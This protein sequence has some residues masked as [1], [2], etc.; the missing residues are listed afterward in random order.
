[1]YNLFGSWAT[2]RSCK[3]RDEHSS[4][5]L[6]HESASLGQTCFCTASLPTALND[7]T[8][9]FSTLITFS[10]LSSYHCMILVSK[11]LLFSLLVFAYSCFAK[12]SAIFCT[13][14]L[15]PL[16]SLYIP[17]NNPLIF[18][19]AFTILNIIFA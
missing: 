12:I 3:L 6:S 11:Y 8:T 7:S 10:C 18:P 1:M 5:N 2:R 13:T 14:D 19:Q 16:L 17:G 9:E 4:Q 15:P